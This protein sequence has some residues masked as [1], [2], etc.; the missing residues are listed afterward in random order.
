MRTLI[1]RGSLMGL[2]A[3]G[4]LLPVYRVPAEETA[5]PAYPVSLSKRVA[6]SVLRR[7]D[8]PP[9][10]NWGEGV[11]LA[12]MMRAYHLTGDRRYLDFVKRF[13][14]HWYEA[15]IGDTLA[16]RCY[17]G[18]WGPAYPMLS[19]YEETRDKRYLALADQVI[20]FMNHKAVRTRDGG[21]SHWDRGKHLFVDTL[22]MCCPVY[23]HA[24][25]IKGEPKLLKRSANQ[26]VLFSKYLRDPETGLYYHF[27]N[28]KNR[29][30][31]D[32]FWCRGNGWVVISLVET[33]KCGKPGSEQFEELAPL[34]EK[35]LDSVAKLQDEETGLWHTVLDEPDT[36][37]ET[38]GSA[39]FLYG[40]AE[41]QRLNLT[42]KRYPRVMEK[43]WAGLATQVAD[44]GRV[45]GTSHGTGPN[46]KKGYSK[47]PVGTYTWG[48]GAFLMAAAAYVESK[49]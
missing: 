20:D 1:G 13:G 4:L 30:R 7:F 37:P 48:T 42:Q 27:Y 3:A 43:A 5:P 22:A 25:R 47:R 10:F 14:D 8:K 32:A 45:I 21:L 46:D 2:L 40:M 41:C 38:S 29:K 17:C 26:L 31:T 44:D 11:L 15:G 34:L 35:Q 9:A 6:D 28:E 24:A 12:G 36:Y 33:L 39:M 49:P 19:L 18:H 23:A 16:N